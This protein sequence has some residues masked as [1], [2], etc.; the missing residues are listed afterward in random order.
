MLVHI[1]Y[2]SNKKK[3][4]YNSKKCPKRAKCEQL[5]I[6]LSCFFF[7]I[8]PLP[9]VQIIMGVKHDRILP[10]TDTHKSFGTYELKP[11]KSGKDLR[12]CLY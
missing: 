10:P 11:L 3:S 2:K 5:T 7:A 9:N 8:Q 6:R 12:Y 1:Y 4:M